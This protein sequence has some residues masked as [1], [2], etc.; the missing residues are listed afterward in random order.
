MWPWGH[1]TVG[2]LVYAWLVWYRD[3]RVPDDLPVLA[4][5]LGTQVPDLVDKSLGWYLGVLPGGRSLAHS[6]FAVAGVVGCAV[7]VVRM[8]GQSSAWV[9]FAAGYTT[10]PV[11]DAME[12]LV[13]G[14]YGGLAYLLWPVAPL[15]D[16]EYV[17]GVAAA[18]EHASLGFFVGELLL[19]A[20][21]AWLWVR[22]GYPG[23]GTLKA[24]IARIRRH[25]SLN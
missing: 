23:V 21:V 11:A 5:A 1:L 25:R 3:R 16:P 13:V 12:P 14:E 6:V 19:T 18:V 24:S 9:A 4:L 2:Y 22:H 10:H 17:D 8:S 7:T 15:P 20:L